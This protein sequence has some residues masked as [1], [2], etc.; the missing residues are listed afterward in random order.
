MIKRKMITTEKKTKEE[1][2]ENSKQRKSNKMGAPVSLAMM[3]V[4]QQIRVE[5]R[6]TCRR[7]SQIPTEIFVP[8]K[9]KK[10]SQISV[11]E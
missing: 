11:H 3:I 2:T 8:C 4:A 6:K 10:E 9:R 5:N 1:T 7:S